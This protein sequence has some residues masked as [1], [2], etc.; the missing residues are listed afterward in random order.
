[1]CCL[2]HLQGPAIAG[3]TRLQLQARGCTVAAITQHAHHNSKC[4]CLQDDL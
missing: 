3:L 4:I 2:P 1:M